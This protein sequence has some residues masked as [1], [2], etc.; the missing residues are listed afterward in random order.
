[1][2]ATDHVPKKDGIPSSWNFI[3]GTFLKVTATDHVPEKGQKNPKRFKS[4]VIC[5]KQAI[6]GC[7]KFSTCKSSFHLTVVL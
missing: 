3:K 7:Y 2:T 6:E 4:V 5:G 1:M